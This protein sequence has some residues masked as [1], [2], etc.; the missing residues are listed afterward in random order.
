MPSTPLLRALARATLLPL[1]LVACE[2][3]GT[4]TAGAGAVQQGAPA[5][6]HTSGV[7]DHV[8]IVSIDGLRPDA[9]DS[10]GAP[11]IR[12]LMR[13]GQYSLSAT[14]VLP[15]T[16]LPSHTS[17]L[18]G[19]EPQAHG[20]TWNSDETSARGYV[21]VPTVFALA[22]AQGLRTAA[23][24]A[25]TKFNHLAAPA[26]LD[27]VRG[28]VGLLR[29]GGIAPWPVA[30]TLR[31]VE[32]HLEHARPNLVFVHIAE[33]DYAGHTFGWMGRR[34][35]SAVRT[36]DQAVAQLL[37]DADRQ[38]GAGR[39]TVIVTADHGGH[40][41]THGT[42]DARDVTIPWVLWGRGVPATGA[43]ASPVRTMDTAATA[44]HLLGL[45]VPDDWSG[46]SVVP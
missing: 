32:R 37:A 12:R 44:L 35:A 4:R 13:E 42:D 41:R 33:A 5:A 31:D 11:T 15:S 26:S 14:T 10:G 27:H 8:L 23:F 20:I 9:I 45:A 6:V 17:M 36:A 1:A 2:H 16:T 7:T 30:R 39:Y 34:Y 40:G 22:H 29:G 18:T 19:V 24:F 3:T 46:R 43:L 25:K 28:P 21:R 38:L